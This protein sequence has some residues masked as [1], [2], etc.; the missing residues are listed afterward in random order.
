M[1]KFCSIAATAAVVATCLG[2]R[3]LHAQ[4][5][6][7]SIARRQ[8]RTLDSLTAA[9][10]ALE[11][12]LDSLAKAGQVGAVATGTDE[13]AALRAAA[14]AATA[15]SAPAQ[16]QQAKLGQNALNPEISVTGDLRANAWK[17]G[18]QTNNFEA[19]EFEFAFQS[20]LDPFATAKVILSVTP[21]GAEVEEGYAFFTALPAHLRL[22]AGRF[23]MLV[24][25]LNRWHA[26]ALPEDEYPLVI[27]TFAGEEGIKGN[28]VSLYSPL[29][30]SVFGGAYELTVQATSGEND[31]LFYGSRRPTVNAQLAGFWQTSRAT[32]AQLSVSGLRGTN[33]DSNLTT[34]LGVVAARFTWRPPQEA[35]A[36]ELTVRGELWGLDRQFTLTGPAPASFGKR[37]GGY[38]DASWKL[39]RQ[40]IASVR[41][42]YVQS[43]E[44]GKDFHEW[45]VTPTLTFWQSE[46]VYIR[47]IY[48][49][50]RDVLSADNHRLS[51]QLN[52]S[53]GPHKHEIF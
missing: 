29:P 33:P 41:G 40:W 4:Q 21:E 23:R 22:D 26:H 49:F 44:L 1:R 27:R 37:L 13:L 9:I 42:D 7:D 35:Q 39:N 6:A 19:R 10:K 5:P 53:M 45:A 18:P 28:G 30:V 17:P 24:G 2:A 16:P 34:K 25:E 48:E 32:F 11:A 36:R 14:T 15:D 43:P 52:F 47:G 46:F 50:R 12:R 20:A 38:G 51:M 8:Q 3:S 31:V